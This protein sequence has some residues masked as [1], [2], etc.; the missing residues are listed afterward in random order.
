MWGSFYPKEVFKKWGFG[1]KRG[2]AGG[3]QIPLNYIFSGFNA[4]KGLCPS[5][6]VGLFPDNFPKNPGRGDP[7]A[8]VRITSGCGP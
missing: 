2:G 6:S 8:V 7:P 5:A 3:D 1:G 4:Q